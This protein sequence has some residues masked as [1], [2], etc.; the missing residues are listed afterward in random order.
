MPDIGQEAAAS[1]T[2]LLSSQAPWHPERAA[3]KSSPSWR[4]G[5]ACL[6]CYAEGA[7]LELTCA[8]VAPCRAG[9]IGRRRTMPALRPDEESANYGFDVKFKPSSGEPD[10]SWERVTG[11]GASIE[12][13]EAT[14]GSDQQGAYIGTHEL[15]HATLNS[16]DEYTESGLPPAGGGG[17]SGRWLLLLVGALLL[18]GLISA[19]ILIFPT[20]LPTGQGTTAPSASVTAAPTSTLQ[21]TAT[22]TLAP[23]ATV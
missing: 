16:L 14:T 18:L 2:A 7:C 19:G 12:Q 9:R 22:A 4:I 6:P 15:G 11:G 8:G 17:N 1:R 21:P 13:T 3:L 5:L 10:P 23:T 20:L